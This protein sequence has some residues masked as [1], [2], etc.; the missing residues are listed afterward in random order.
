[1]TDNLKVEIIYFYALENAKQHH[2]DKY[3]VVHDEENVTPV[4]RRGHKFNIA[5]R[6]IGRQYSSGTDNVSVIFNYGKYL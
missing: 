6:F 3:E 2:T 4:L 1:M 5:I